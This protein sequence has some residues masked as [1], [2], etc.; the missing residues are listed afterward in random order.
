MAG[1]RLQGCR[2]GPKVAL[3]VPSSGIWMSCLALAKPY[4]L[5]YCT[6]VCGLGAWVRGNMIRWVH[7]TRVR[8]YGGTASKVGEDIATGRH[9]HAVRKERRLP[10]CL[11]LP[12]SQ[13]TD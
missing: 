8:G 9:I 5:G 13:W 1:G 11:S 4:I 7:G 2:G 10:P 3:L 12:P 6:A